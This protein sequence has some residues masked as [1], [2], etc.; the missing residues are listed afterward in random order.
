VGAS[1]TFSA[2]QSQTVVSNTVIHT[3]TEQKMATGYDIRYNVLNDAKNI[4]FEKWHEQCNLLRRNA[5]LA[6]SLLEPY[7]PAPTAAEIKALAEELY[8]FVQRK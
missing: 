4:L 2:I 5:D 7:P 6:R 1:P 3:H 8:E